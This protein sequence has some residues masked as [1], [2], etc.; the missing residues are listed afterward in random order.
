MHAHCCMHE[1]SH[2][3]KSVHT[4]C[5]YGPLLLGVN[6]LC[7]FLQRSLNRSSS[8]CTVHWELLSS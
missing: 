6:E 5:G 8:L 2:V 1:A 3:H 4:V 7:K